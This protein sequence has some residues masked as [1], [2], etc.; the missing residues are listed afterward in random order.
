M[1]GRRIEGKERASEEE[2]E[3]IDRTSSRA[4]RPPSSLRARPAG[5]SEGLLSL[6]ISLPLFFRNDGA[7][8]FFSRGYRVSCASPFVPFPHAFFPS[9]FASVYPSR[10]TPG[11]YQKKR[12]EKATRDLA[13]C[14]KNHHRRCCRRRYHLY[15]VIAAAAAATNSLAKTTLHLRT[16]AN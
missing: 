5:R 1:Q 6:F 13:V 7:L 14:A 15:R 16:C 9:L 4:T 2:R 10:G 8:L 3:D 12:R 11:G